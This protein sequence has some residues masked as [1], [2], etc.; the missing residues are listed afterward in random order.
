MSG[1]CGRRIGDRVAGNAALKTELQF[2][3]PSA[4]LL[5]D[6]MVLEGL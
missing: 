6:E 2:W 5:K 3:M 4:A 1:V